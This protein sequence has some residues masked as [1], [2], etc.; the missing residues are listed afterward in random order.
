MV[1]YISNNILVRRPGRRNRI[2]L[3]NWDWKPLHCLIYFSEQTNSLAELLE[4]QK[5]I[6]ENHCCYFKM[7]KKFINT[8][9]SVSAMST[10]STSLAP[11]DSSTSMTTGPR[12]YQYHF[13]RYRSRPGMI[14]IPIPWKRDGSFPWDPRETDE[15]AKQH[16][17]KMRKDDEA[18]VKAFLKVNQEYSKMR[19]TGRRIPPT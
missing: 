9:P 8:K 3:N 2:I 15:L 12:P 5:F 19:K 7:F 1:F 4:N 16:Y 11:N 17:E 14:A 6:I 10:Q 18:A 13:K